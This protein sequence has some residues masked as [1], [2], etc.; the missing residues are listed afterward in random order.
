MGNATDPEKEHGQ[1]ARL[2]LRGGSRPPAPSAACRTPSGNRRVSRRLHGYVTAETW[3]R[4]GQLRPGSSACTDG[5][6]GP[7]SPEA[8]AQREE[9][10]GE[11]KGSA[12]LPSPRTRPPRSPPPRWRSLGNH[13]PPRHLRFPRCGLGQVS[14]RLGVSLSSFCKTGPGRARVAEAVFARR[15]WAELVLL[16]TGSLA[17]AV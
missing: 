16:G 1:P 2:R 7:A 4:G 10:T 8:N 14:S 15:L 6:A 12:G 5:Q 9:K 17:L 13:L 3:A 11:R